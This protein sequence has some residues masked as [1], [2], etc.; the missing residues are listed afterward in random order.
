MLNCLVI[1]DEPL[2]IRLLSDYVNKTDG[3]TLAGSFTSA[4]QALQFV[5][6]SSVDLILLD[7][8]MPDLTGLQFSKI[9]NGKIPIILTT[10]YEQYALEGYELNVIDY[11][12]KPISLERFLVA[13]HKARQ[14]IQPAPLPTN[15]SE[16]RGSSPAHPG[17]IFVKTSYKTQKVNLDDILY[18]EGLGDYVRIH[19]T[20]ERI[21][22]LENMKHFAVTLP[23]DR[24]IRVHRSFL[25]AL[26]KIEFI[27]RNRIIIQET[28]LPIGGTYQ[29]EFWN[30]INGSQE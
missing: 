3:L 8:Q 23:A 12:L 21:M 27:E 16:S 20:S 2:A 11:L 24:F 14:R 10:A 30:R 7:V 1:D 25:I 18:F 29:K 19:T 9:I 13:I 15:I 26:D 17:Y 28:Y 5:E 6:Q 22:T 4:I